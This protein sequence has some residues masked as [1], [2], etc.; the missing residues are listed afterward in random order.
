MICRMLLTSH[1]RGAKYEPASIH[2]YLNIIGVYDL[3]Q[4][5]CMSPLR[6]PSGV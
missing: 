3:W 4:M 2:L 1:K 6:V 5:A